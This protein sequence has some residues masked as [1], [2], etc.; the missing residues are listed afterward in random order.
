MNYQQYSN[1]VSEFFFC[2]TCQYSHMHWT[3]SPKADY[4]V[5][6]ENCGIPSYKYNASLN[7]YNRENKVTAIKSQQQTKYERMVEEILPKGVYAVEKLED[8]IITY[9]ER[10]ELLNYLIV[11]WQAMESFRKSLTKNVVDNPKMNCDIK[12]EWVK[13]SLQNIETLLDKAQ[14]ATDEL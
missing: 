10:Q 11:Y 3:T 14:K 4:V 7:G 2:E 13:S 12:I 8:K 6:C 5:I 1:N 9:D